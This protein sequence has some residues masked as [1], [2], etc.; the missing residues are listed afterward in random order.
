MRDTARGPREVA[1]TL[2]TRGLREL[3]DLVRVLRAAPAVTLYRRSS[4]R[5]VIGR[6]IARWVECLH[7]GHA[8]ETTTRQLAW[9]LAAFPEFRNLFFYRIGPSARLVRPLYRP[10]STL[11]IE[12]KAIGGG[13]FI[14]HGFATIIVADYIG[15]DCWINQQVTLG[16]VYDRGAPVI[17]DRVTIA[18]G[19]VV[20]GP[21]HIGDGATVGANTT[22]VK[23]VPAG[24][25]VVSAPARVIT[26][27]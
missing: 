7:A 23:N 13:L 27:A 5:D 16:H 20:I 1:S 18:S 25:V 6:D 8:S 15:V 24:A 17:G 11:H 10:E 4:R 12:A 9:L 2:M 22:V 21:I 19:A 3:R 26:P 14:Q